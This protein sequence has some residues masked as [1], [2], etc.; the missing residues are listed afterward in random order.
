MS[1]DFHLRQQDFCYLNNN[2]VAVLEMEH[3]N[4]EPEERCY[5]S[6]YCRNSQGQSNVLLQEIGHP[7][8]SRVWNLLHP[9]QFIPKSPSTTSNLIK[10][11][12]GFLRLLS[13]AIYKH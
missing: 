1:R 8:L 5:N 10:W 11:E 3:R 4:I 13:A 12:L 9:S 7:E 6:K 2:P